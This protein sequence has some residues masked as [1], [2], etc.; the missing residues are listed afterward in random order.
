M[1][2]SGMEAPVASIEQL[3]RFIVF[4]GWIRRSDQT[5]KQDAFI[6]P[7]DLELS[8]T[9]HKNLSE[10][11]LWRIGQRV[12][13]ARPAKLH[14]RADIRAANVRQQALDVEPNPVPGNPNHANVIGWPADKPAQKIIAQE[15]AAKAH[16][17][18]ALQPK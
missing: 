17:L 13:D 8:V 16:F 4:S 11:E 18:P 15:L 12:A 6:P 7:P 9:R 14:G 2:N 5:V 10:R 3:A 1:S